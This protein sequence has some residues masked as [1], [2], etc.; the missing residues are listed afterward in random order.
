MHIESW[1]RI[2]DV[3][4]NSTKSP[5]LDESELLFGCSNPAPYNSKVQF[6]FSLPICDNPWVQFVA[7]GL[8]A[9][10]LVAAC[11]FMVAML[12]AFRRRFERAIGLGFNIRICYMV[13]LAI[14]ASG[15]VLLETSLRRSNGYVFYLTVNVGS[16]ALEL[17][18]PSERSTNIQAVYFVGSIVALGLLVMDYVVAPRLCRSGHVD[19]VPWSVA[20][21]RFWGF[22]LHPVDEELDEKPLGSPRSVEEQIPGQSVFP[23]HRCYRNLLGRCEGGKADYLIIGFGITSITARA[24]ISTFRCLLFMYTLQFSGAAVLASFEARQ[25][26]AAGM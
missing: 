25:C 16:R 2:L 10:T 19:G 13:A 8:A 3:F 11:L 26:V 4:R 14:T 24:C 18:G 20:Y 7:L 1:S 21:L 22:E 17:P 23:E 9:L 6:N 5:P 12:P 15:A